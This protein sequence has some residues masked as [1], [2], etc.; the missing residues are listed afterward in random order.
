MAEK[1]PELEV[2][3]W[4]IGEQHLG[5]LPGERVE[6]DPKQGEVEG[7]RKE[8]AWGCA[9]AGVGANRVPLSC[10]RGRGAAT[11]LL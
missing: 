11:H 8:A 6:A 4:E 9:R 1:R 3:G 7:N 5:R 10:H 2:K